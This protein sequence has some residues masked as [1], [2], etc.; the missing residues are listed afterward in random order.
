M[1]PAIRERLVCPWMLRAR[2]NERQIVRRAER[3]E[4]LSVAQRPRHVGRAVLGRL[5]PGTVTQMTVFQDRR[6]GRRLW[7]TH[8]YTCPHGFILFSGFPDPK[9]CWEPN[10]TLRTDPAH[11]DDR[12]YTCGPTCAR[13]RARADAAGDLL[14]DYRHVCDECETWLAS[15]TRS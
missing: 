3:N 10:E 14:A 12:S 2:F 5:P 4:M 1:P 15:R 8:H 7:E 9:T 6:T 11:P 13:D